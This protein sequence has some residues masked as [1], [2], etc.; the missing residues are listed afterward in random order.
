MTH[1]KLNTIL[2]V[3]ICVAFLY[4]IFAMRLAGLGDFYRLERELSPHDYNTY[5]IYHNGIDIRDLRLEFYSKDMR[6]QID[7]FDV[8]RQGEIV[9]R[10][11][12]EY[13]LYKLRGYYRGTY[14][15]SDGALKNRRDY[16]AHEMIVIA[17]EDTVVLHGLTDLDGPRGS[18]IY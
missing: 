7:S 17:T 12:Q 18:A 10:I 14:I 1:D 2:F 3:T 8:V 11:P 15:G 6:E 5:T 16:V 9:G 4:L 13:G